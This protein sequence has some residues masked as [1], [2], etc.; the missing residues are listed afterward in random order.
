MS[1]FV[2][3]SLKPTLAL[4]P[5]KR[6]KWLEKAV[7]ALKDGAVRVSD[8]FDI[9]G[10][11]KFVNGIPDGV[12]KKMRRCLSGS[13]LNLFSGKQRDGLERSV[14]FKNFP[15]EAPK[16]RKEHVKEVDEGKMDDMLA[17]CRA[18]VRDNETLYE[19]RQKAL[20]D[21]EQKKK[22]DELDRIRHAEEEKQRKLDEEWEREEQQR[23]EEERL[24]KDEE[25]EERE[26]RRQ[27]KGIT[28][29]ALTK[30]ER[31]LR[32]AEFAFEKGPAGDHCGRSQSSSRCSGSG[33]SRSSSRG[34][35]RSQDKRDPGHARSRSRSRSGQ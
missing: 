24:A 4:K 12:G 9:I 1:D 14:L 3:C 25:E 23:A 26:E 2:D 18:F 22:Q 33:S 27:G 28:E 30:L 13:T 34:H 11:P 21:A 6:L 10:H 31:D 17:R 20:D 15:E 32:D 8:V 5:E 29:D 35:Q 7:S 19:D 16:P